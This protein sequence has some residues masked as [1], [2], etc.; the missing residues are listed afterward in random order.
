M[1]TTLP[2][3]MIVKWQSVKTVMYS[4]YDMKI[5]AL[6]TI[7]LA[8]HEKLDIMMAVTA[9]SATSATFKATITLARSTHIALP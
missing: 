4:S 8:V 3:S 9:L 2:D 1:T 6:K 5:A 7:T